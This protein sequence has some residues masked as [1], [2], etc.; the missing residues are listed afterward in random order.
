M[1][2]FPPQD[3]SHLAS[4]PQDWAIDRA[5]QL[6]GGPRE[7]GIWPVTLN[8]VHRGW[9]RINPRRAAQ[10]RVSWQD[11]NPSALDNVAQAER[12]GIYYRVFT[13]RDVLAAN[14][15]MHGVSASF[16][17]TE[18]WRN[19]PQGVLDFD[20]GNS[21]VLGGHHLAV[22]RPQFYMP[23]PRGW[24]DEDFLAGPNG[25]GTQWGNRGY[26][27]M[28]YS[29]FNREMYEAWASDLHP[30]IKD[31]QGSGTVHLGAAL[32]PESGCHISAFEVRD[33]AADNLLAWTT[34]VLRRGEIHVEEFYVKPEAR[35][36]G[37][38]R[39]MMAEVR[40]IMAKTDLPCRFWIPFADAEQ[41]DSVARLRAFFSHAGLGFE[42]APAACAAYCA[43][44][45]GSEEPLA[46]E[47]PPKPTYLF[48]HDKNLDFGH[49]RVDWE[50]APRHHGVSADFV[51]QVREVF[52]AHDEGLHRLA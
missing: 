35:R 7:L 18:Q 27:A 9:G 31:L 13:A 1:H 38:G 19:P 16:R 37:H 40:R 5:L 29:F 47:M 50:S 48:T 39:A 44:E 30:P 2:Q 43:V 23:V 49:G 25:W 20:Q 24:L 26:F 42:P 17:V 8:R 3:D 4:D 51:D 33:L 22:G 14:D 41:P 11:D 21:P 46:F 36:R 45:G 32:Q 52:L 10:L 28:P 34:L 15:R 6:E 12:M